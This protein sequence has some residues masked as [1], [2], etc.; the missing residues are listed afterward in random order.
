MAMGAWQPFDNFAK[1]CMA[2]TIDLDTDSFRVA[3]V[4]SSYTLDLTDD[5]WSEISGNEVANGDGYT[6]HG[7][8]L[9]SVTFTSSTDTH[10]WDCADFSW[11]A[12]GS[13]ITARFAVIVHDAN[14]DNSLA[15]T[16]KVCAIA[17]LDNT[18]AD[19]SRT[20]GQNLEIQHSANGIVQVDGRA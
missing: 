16:D 19:V 6:T 11:T 8:A 10:T 13:G 14:G 2:G 17:L 7:N 3:L 5:Q 15:T 9:S 12:S 18:P 1:H 4:T 20:A